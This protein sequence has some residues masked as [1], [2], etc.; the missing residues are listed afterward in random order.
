MPP[1]SIRSSSVRY[2]NLQGFTPEGD[3]QY[4]NEQQCLSLIRSPLGQQC[5]YLIIE[6]EKRTNIIDILTKTRGPCGRFTEGEKR[7]FWSTYFY[8]TFVCF[9]CI[10]L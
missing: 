10:F 5:Q 3:Y 4:Y 2:L 1:F 8:Y 7:N 9:H 6:V